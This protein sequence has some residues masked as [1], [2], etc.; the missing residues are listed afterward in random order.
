[1]GSGVLIKPINAGTRNELKVNPHF[2]RT[3]S[4]MT[5]YLE[6][7]YTYMCRYLFSLISFAVTSDTFF[8]YTISITRQLFPYIDTLVYLKTMQNQFIPVISN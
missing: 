3:L 7:K 2:L 6:Q 5:H 1:M 4:T 8:L